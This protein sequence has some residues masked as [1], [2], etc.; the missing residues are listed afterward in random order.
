MNDYDDIIDQTFDNHGQCSEVTKIPKANLKMAKKMGADGCVAH[1]IQWFK[2]KDWYELHQLDVEAA[3]EDSIES[4]KKE[5]LRATIILKKLEQ[6]KKEGLYLDP[7]EVKEFILGM[8]IAQA[9]SFKALKYELT[10]KIV[11]KS[12]SEVEGIF[13]KAFSK[14]PEQL[15][16]DFTKWISTLGKT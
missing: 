9:S 8:A 7:T 10:S 3:L 14:F 16:K 12:T 11:G 6:K 5:D 1:R 13:D 15:K 4:L 2:F